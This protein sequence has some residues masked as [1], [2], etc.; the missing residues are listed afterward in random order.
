MT[1]R[2]MLLAPFAAAAA[3]A[4]ARSTSSVP[5]DS[6]PVPLLTWEVVEFGGPKRFDS[7]HEALDAVPQGGIVVCAPCGIFA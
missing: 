1:R 4:V 7:L 5:V 2:Q 3:P 6:W